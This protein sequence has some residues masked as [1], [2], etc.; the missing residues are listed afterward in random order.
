MHD[1]IAHTLSYW[2]PFKMWNKWPVDIKLWGHFTFLLLRKYVIII[3]MKLGIIFT[4]SRFLLSHREQLQWKYRKVLSFIN[5]VSIIPQNYFFFSWPP[6]DFTWE[7]MEKTPKFL[8][9]KTNFIITSYLK[10]L[11]NIRIM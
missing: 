6:S 10:I 7:V 9:S 1:L 11:V 2:Y 3:P 8:R 4:C 5:V